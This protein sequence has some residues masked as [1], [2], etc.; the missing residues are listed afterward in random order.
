MITITLNN[1]M[2]SDFIN[3]IKS[4]LKTQPK[5]TYNIK[6]ELSVNGYTKEFEDEIDKSIKEIENGEFVEFND[7]QKAVEFLNA[8]D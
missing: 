8:K 3:A 4:M 5:E 1:N 7:F 2:N 6:E